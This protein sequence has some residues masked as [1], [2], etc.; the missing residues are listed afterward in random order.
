MQ[1]LSLHNHIVNTDIVPGQSTVSIDNI[2]GSYFGDLPAIAE[3]LTNW[4]NSEEVGDKTTEIIAS[5]DLIPGNT[6]I[7]LNSY[8]QP[9]YP[10]AET[11]IRKII[12]KSQGYIENQ[13]TFSIDDGVVTWWYRNDLVFE[14][15]FVEFTNNSTFLIF[16]NSSVFFDDCDIFENSTSSCKI[17]NAEFL[18]FN[19]CRIKDLTTNDPIAIDNLTDLEMIDNSIEASFSFPFY[20]LNSSCS[21]PRIFNITNNNFKGNLLLDGFL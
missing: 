16:E 8:D 10:I 18:S 13:P 11:E 7:S 4:F 19:N 2:T 5:A 21:Y 3:H 6:S 15:V 1:E 9:I 20:V 14:K 12:F 17:R